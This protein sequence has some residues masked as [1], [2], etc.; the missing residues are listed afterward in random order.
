VIENVVDP[1]TQ[2]PN[3]LSYPNTWTGLELKFHEIG[4]VTVDEYKFDNEDED[5]EDGR[6]KLSWLM[7]VFPIGLVFW[8][9]LKKSEDRYWLLSTRF[10]LCA[11]GHKVELAMFRIQLFFLI[12][13][14]RTMARKT[15]HTV[16]KYLCTTGT[17]ARRFSK[18]ESTIGNPPRVS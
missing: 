8:Y 2:F 13:K 10:L 4:A 3:P 5:E 12:F 11:L 6:E 9:W 18:T 17:T 14:T 15:F 1:G 16:A 7:S